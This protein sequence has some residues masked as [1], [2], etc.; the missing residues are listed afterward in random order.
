[1]ASFVGETFVKRCY[2]PQEVQEF[3][4]TRF[5]RQ[6]LIVAT[7][8]PFDFLG[9]FK[10]LPDQK[11][12]CAE[13]NGIIYNFT[14]YQNNNKKFPVRFYDTIRYFPVGVEV[15]GKIVGTP[16]MKHPSFFPKKPKNKEEWAELA[17]YCDNDAYISF[18]FMKNFVLK[19]I[20]E[21]GLRLKITIASM[22]M[23]D[24]KT[25]YLK[26]KIPIESEEKHELAFKAY[27]GGRTEVF[28]RGTF[29]DVT[30]YDFNSLYPTVMLKE[31][32]NPKN[33]YY[34]KQISHY[35]VENYEGVCYCEGI[36]D[37]RFV[38]LLPV[39]H[40]HKGSMKLVFPSGLIKGHYTFVELREAQKNGFTITKLGEGVYYTKTKKYFKE[41]VTDKYSLRQKQKA[42]GDP[43]E[44]MTK[45][46][47]NSLYGKFGFNYREKSQIVH[48]SEFTNKILDEATSITDLG[49][50]YFA[51]NGESDKP[52]N[53]SFPIWASYI[54]AYARIELYK[55]LAAHHPYVLYCDTD[56]VFFRDGYTIEQG[57]A[58]GDMKFEYKVPEGMFVRPKF[59]FTK[60][61]K[62]KGVKAP[63][64]EDG[65]KQDIDRELFIKLVGGEKITEDFFVKY[66]T[67][68]RSREHHKWGKLEFNQIIQKEKRL[69]VEDSKRHWVTEFNLNQ[70]QTSQP[71]LFEEKH[72]E[73]N[74][75]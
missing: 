49:N 59:Y 17:E 20:K 33:G 38:P 12:R 69:S 14:Y 70:Q 25:N 32:P 36:Q 62:I 23:C 2:S 37:K 48:E 18:L 3:L 10:S 57:D 8:L 29:K 28:R 53:Y 45:L 43:M 60:K 50:G 61:A 31:L 46:I 54:T 30:C 73:Q 11:F 9:V 16:K 66:R 1:M 21:N 51:V 4:N 35:D 56:S 64:D 63:L 75:A 44:L 26:E 65:V 68:L 19:Y 34:A 13:R 15:L 74:D 67:A 39:R 24:W 58:L 6:H 5:A 27:Y 41:F 22:S 47:M 42:D 72:Y 71:H 40:V 52:P 7:N 55:K